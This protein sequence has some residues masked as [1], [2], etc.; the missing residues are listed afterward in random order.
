MLNLFKTAYERLKRYLSIGCAVCALPCTSVAD[1]VL[2]SPLAEDVSK[3]QLGMADTDNSTPTMCSD[4]LAMINYEGIAYGIYTFNAPLILKNPEDSIEFSYILNIAHTGVP[5]G[6]SPGIGI[7]TFRGETNIHA[8]LGGK[9]NGQFN[10]TTSKTEATKCYS[11]SSNGQN[12]VTLLPPKTADGKVA[13]PSL[14]LTDVIPSLTYTTIQGYIKWDNQVEQFSAFFNVGGKITGSLELG[15]ELKFDGIGITLSG[16]QNSTAKFSNLQVSYHSEE[17]PEPSIPTLFLV[18]T[19]LITF[20][21]RA[22]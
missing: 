10:A 2:Y 17:V 8:G 20:R 6:S 9:A 22:A 3:W 4:A 11:F 12:G 1:D 16:P 5:Y 14:S 13:E 7:L 18:A 21:R 19:W 15:K